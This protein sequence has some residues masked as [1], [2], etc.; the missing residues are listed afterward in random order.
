M[1]VSSSN[2][3]RV[4]FIEET[5]YGVV[6]AGNFKTARFT[7]ENF[8]GTPNTVES[9]Q[10]RVDRMS[11]G[12]IVTG[13]DVKGTM[14]FELAKEAPIDLFLASAMYSDW[15][16]SSLITVDLSI[17]AS[18]K[19]I[20]RSAGSYITDG[21]KIGDVVTLGGFA[22]A[23]NNVPIMVCEI[24][25]ATVIRYVGPS[26]M[27]TEVGPTGLTTFKVA[28]KLSI[29]ITK[30][31]FSIV[32]EFLDLTTKSI[33]YK[34]FI[35]SSMDLNVAFGSIVTGS[36]GFSGNSYV[37]GTLATDRLNNGRTIDA[38][39]TT[40]SLNGS[41]DMP[42][43]ASSALGQLDDAGFDIKSVGIKLDNNLTA[44]TVIGNI[45]P[46]DYTTGTSKID[47]DIAAYLTDAAWSVLGKKLTQDP[48]ALG[49]MVKN[50]GGWYAFFLP[51]IQ[52]SFEDPVSGG[53]NQDVMLPMKG[54]AK[55][56][57]SGESALTIFR[58]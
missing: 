39:A 44:Q 32:K 22:S 4:T 49:F 50:S 10:I 9:K 21:V 25:S 3:V 51:Q 12:Q 24:V 34:G 2:L 28:D 16:V 56:G 19:R 30:K 11:S 42:F 41:V 48:F 46:R 38:A 58:S 40:N 15:V 53:Q 31:S 5:V 35:V 29:G 52:V 54:M 36:F 8:S 23:L 47:L 14:A 13:L 43:V 37:T 57:E 17:N 20:T 7:S 26:T 1:S 55:V 18:T 45:A 27:V 6:P 33:N